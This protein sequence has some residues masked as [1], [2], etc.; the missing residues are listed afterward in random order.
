MLFGVSM[1]RVRIPPRVPAF[2]YI[3][4]LPVLAVAARLPDTPV[5]NIVHIVAGAALVWLPVAM[6]DRQRVGSMP[7]PSAAA[8][9]A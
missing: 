1:E 9:P 5:T 4:A 8:R 2:A 7:V 3:V 6:F